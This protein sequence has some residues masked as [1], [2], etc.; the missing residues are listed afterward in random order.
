MML[1]LAA[2]NEHEA[3][4]WLLLEAKVNMD[5]KIK[6]EKTALHRAAKNGTRHLCRRAPR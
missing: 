4:V 1:H 3:M 2:V 5:E 6:H